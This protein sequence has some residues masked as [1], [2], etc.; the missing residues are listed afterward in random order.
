MIYF[1]IHEQQGEKLVAACDREIMGKTISQGVIEF[2]VDKRFYGD[3]L[4]NVKDFTALLKDA[5]SANLMG[6]K[7][8][9]AAIECGLVDRDCVLEVAGIKHAQIVVI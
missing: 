2:K 7:V 8:V 5:T 9:D 1:K 4:I 3:T 6:N